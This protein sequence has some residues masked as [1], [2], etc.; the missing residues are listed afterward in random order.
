LK[1][2]E[3]QGKIDPAIVKGKNLLNV[4]DI[5]LAQW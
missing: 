4:D 3:A 5:L 2:L 1:V